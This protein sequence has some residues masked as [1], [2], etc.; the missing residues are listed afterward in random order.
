MQTCRGCAEKFPDRVVV[1]GEVRVVNRRKYCLECS[2]FGEHNTGIPKRLRKSNKVTCSG[3]SRKYVYE[4]AIKGQP[5]PG[6]TKERCNSCVANARRSER[7]RRAV[8]YKGG[9]CVICDY[10]RCMR[11]LAFHH[12]DPKKKDIEINLSSMCRSWEKLRRE[13]D[14]CVLLCTNCH[15]EVH[16]GLV[17]VPTKALPRY[18]REAVGANP[19][20]RTMGL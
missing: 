2:P 12:L 11:S 8:E 20:R 5:R 19:T 6:H 1:N 7:K 9:K 17:Q 13:L 18:R 3:C 10:S 16:D 4:S 15:G 14:K